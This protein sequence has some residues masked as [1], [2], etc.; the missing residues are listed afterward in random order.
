M[1]E[2]DNG[3]YTLLIREHHLDTFGHM[4]NATYLEILEEARWELIHSRGY[5]M[6]Y[7][8][9]SKQGPVILDVHLKFLKELRLRDK[10]KI[11]TKVL[12]YPG[13]VGRLQQ[14]ILNQNGELAATAVFTFGLFDLAQRKLIDPTPEWRHAI[15]LI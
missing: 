6:S 4:N 7:I 3:I 1:A 10:V 11:T 9:K 5:G 2:T 13:K 8:H 14:D 12:D 15:G